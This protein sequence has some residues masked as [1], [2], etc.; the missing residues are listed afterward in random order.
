MH[1]GRETV[2]NLFRAAALV[3]LAAPA[4]AFAQQAPTQ[5]Y[6]GANVGASRLNVDCEDLPTCDKDGVAYK[7]LVGRR[8]NHVF[9][10]EAAYVNL[11]RSK[12]A[13][14]LSGTKYGINAKSSGFLLGVALRGAI[15]P[16]VG[17][18]GRAG[19]SV[20]ETTGDAYLDNV[21]A[22]RSETS[23]LP[24]FGI[25]GEYAVQRD[26]KLTVAFDQYRV[27]YVGYE[28]KVRTFT[29]GAQ[30]EF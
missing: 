27:D 16:E 7:V 1:Q 17:V 13:G 25:A 9:S 3:A 21:N 19:L 18:L 30:Y 28:F 24:Y 4:F 29:V 11:G 22:S 5:Y 20:L 23:N 8:S 10:A 15:T 26:L 12:F 6:V 2:K 14:T